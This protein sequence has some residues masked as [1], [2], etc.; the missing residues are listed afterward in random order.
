VYFISGNGTLHVNRM[1]YSVLP[2]VPTTQ[3]LQ[4]PPPPP[5]AGNVQLTEQP[6]AGRQG[7]G[8]PGGAP[9]AGGRGGGRGGGGAAAAPVEKRTNLNP[10]G[11]VEEDYPLD[12]HV[13][14]FLDCMASRKPCNASMDIGYYSALPALLAL[15]SLKAGKMMG[16]DATKRVAVPL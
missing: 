10:R 7:A 8:G 5:T 13:Q 4:G 11:G 1:G 3:R 9:G 2:P 15:E 6:G 14:N 16:F 12:A